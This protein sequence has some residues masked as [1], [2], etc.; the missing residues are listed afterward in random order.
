MSPLYA[1]VFPV[2]KTSYVKSTLGIGVGSVNVM[3]FVL[4]VKVAVG[5]VAIS[6]SLSTPVPSQSCVI[7]SLESVY[8]F[9]GSILAQTP[10][11]VHAPVDEL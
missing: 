3:L 4:P 10:G 6:T 9:S 11:I 1:R 5:A 8:P 7:L 2:P